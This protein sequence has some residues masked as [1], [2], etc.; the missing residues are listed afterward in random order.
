ME[1]ILKGAIVLVAL[2]IVVVLVKNYFM[3]DNTA[4]TS[5]LP[6]F[7]FSDI[8]RNRINADLLS[9]NGLVV[10]HFNLTCN[11]CIEIASEIGKRKDIFKD[12]PIIL[13]ATAPDTELINWVKQIGLDGLSNL[14]VISDKDNLFYTYFGEETTPL[15]LVYNDQ[16]ALVNRFDRELSFVEFMDAVVAQKKG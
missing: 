4:N 8:E 16:G 9:S 7:E 6:D 13:I 5:K 12:V 10:L 1:K 2:F 11:H 3:A 15:M 14:K